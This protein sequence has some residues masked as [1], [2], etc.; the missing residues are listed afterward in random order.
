MGRR[1]A[2]SE[3]WCARR[4]SYTHISTYIHAYNNKDKDD[5]IE[6]EGQSQKAKTRHD[7]QLDG[8]SG[9]VL[10]E[11]GRSGSVMGLSQSDTTC[12]E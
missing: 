1:G 10:I 8:L 7:A 2:G 5:T 12:R 11:G 3:R 6:K 4:D 9:R